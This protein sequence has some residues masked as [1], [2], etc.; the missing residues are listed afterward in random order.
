VRDFYKFIRIDFK[1]HYGSEFYCP[2]SLFRVYGL[3]HL[4]EWKWEVWEEESRAKRDELHARVEAL[5][6]PVAAEEHVSNVT[7]SSDLPA[8]E[9]TVDSAKSIHSASMT[10][11]TSEVNNGQSVSFGP[12]PWD[13][14]NPMTSVALIQTLSSVPSIS[15]TAPVDGRSSAHASHAVVIDTAPVL[16]Q[17]NNPSTSVPVASPDTTDSTAMASP[18]PSVEPIQVE[19]NPSTS[20]TIERVEKA[21]LPTG[22]ESIYRTI[23]NRVTSLE[24]NHTLYSRYI[25]EQMFGVRE[26]LNRVAE[27]IGRL[28]GVVSLFPLSL[29]TYFLTSLFRAKLTQRIINAPCGT[30]SVKPKC[31]K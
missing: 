4:E 12:W 26:V 19:P 7:P 5:P 10:G 9:V 6:Q 27:D 3:T 14:S 22:G 16:E 13:S 31:W 2:V 29:S 15:D 20:P 21:P 11:T 1:S 18:S 17:R 24:T 8:H 23:M 25:E 30:G 28:E